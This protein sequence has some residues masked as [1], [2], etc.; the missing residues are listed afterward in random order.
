MQP[1]AA[2]GDENRT[3][4]EAARRAQIVAA[5][6]D[7]IAEVGYP[8]ASFA[9]IA[10]RLGISRGLIS[11]HFAGKDDLIRQVAIEIIGASRSYM[12][13]RILAQTTGP[14]TLRT[15][16]ESNLE[17]MRDHRNYMV[18]ILEIARNGGL[19]SGGRQRVDGREVGVALRLLEEL[20]ARLQSE[21]ELRADFD[22]EVMALA[23]RAA[24]DA[25][26]LRLAV[27]PDLDLDKYG[28]ELAAAFDLATRI[29]A[30][31]DP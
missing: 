11:Y 2:A 27:N 23:I 8:A 15:Y 16:I 21:G 12:L 24:I 18:A 5:A 4:I 22:P 1:G 26:P 14:A 3:F 6:I 7:T 10:E 9:R 28:K 31:P 17:F 13:P 25:V 20:L 30:R 29:E 19:T